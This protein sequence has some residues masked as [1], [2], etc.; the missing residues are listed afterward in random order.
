[1]SFP[2]FN[3][4][5]GGWAAQYAINCGGVLSIRM[6]NLRGM[7]IGIPVLAKRTETKCWKR[8]FI[9]LGPNSICLFLHCKKL[10]Q[11]T[12]LWIRCFYLLTFA[13]CFMY[14]CHSKFYLHEFGNLKCCF[15]CFRSLRVHHLQTS[16][17]DVCRDERQV[18]LK[19]SEMR[20][21]QRGSRSLSTKRFWSAVL[22]SAV[23]QMCHDEKSVNKLPN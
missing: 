4:F 11:L 16:S 17:S 3:T 10:T 1:M 8:H 5:Q 22:R 23:L 19:D 20:K 6:N 14:L 21:G 18:Q 2:L 9:T 12:F 13:Y 7:L 15:H